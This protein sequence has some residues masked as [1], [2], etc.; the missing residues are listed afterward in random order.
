MN[1]LARLFWVATLLCALIGGVMAALRSW[2]PVT[3][4]AWAVVPYVIA[5]AWWTLT[6]ADRDTR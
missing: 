2:S 3:A 1:T 4:L 6:L 5:Q